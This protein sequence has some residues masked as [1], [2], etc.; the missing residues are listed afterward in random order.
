MRSFLLAFL[1]VIALVQPA[2]AASLRRLTVLDSPVVR[3]RDLFNDAGPLADQ[4]LGPGPEPG[5]RIVVEAPQLA[6]IAQQFGVA[7]QPRSS[8]DR[9]VLDRPGRLLPEET[10]RT[11]LRQALFG[12]GAPADGEVVLSGFQAPMVPL[13]GKVQLA[14]EQLDFSAAS[15]R[16][17]ATV[18]VS[19]DGMDPLRVRVVGD[20]QAMVTVP[21]LA[22]RLPAGHV[23]AASDLRLAR[24]RQSLVQA[25]TLRVAAEAVGKAL[26]HFTAAGEP[27]AAADLTAP[28][29][30]ERNARVSMRLAMPG[31]S[32]TAQGI[33]LDAGAVGQSV[34]V[35]NPASRAIIAAEV[36]G[37]GMVQ[38]LPGSMPL[39]PGSGLARMAQR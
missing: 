39:E 27:L 19:G 25:D 16:F 38:V 31:L 32:V 30:V 21:V 35:L 10:L 3:L 33:A 20:D 29:V 23:L 37:P 1:F 28:V 8:A 24:V 26:R 5:G 15:G 2:T 22:R 4:V 14:V 17:A 6:A 9:A 12:V 34:R 7:W 36:A 13:G 11:V 18:L